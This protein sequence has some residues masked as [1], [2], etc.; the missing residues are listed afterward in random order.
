MMKY[1]FFDIECAN[2]FGGSGKICEFGYVITDERFQIEEKN[3]YLINP[4]ASFDW[5]VVKNMLAYPTDAYYASDTYPVVFPKIKRLFDL[6][7]TMMIGHTVDADAGYL[8]DEARRYNLPFFNYSFYDAKEMYTAY[9][10]TSKSVG[11]EE[12]GKNLGSKGP[13][14]A[15]KSVDDAEATMNTVKAM[16]SALEIPLCE[17][18]SLCPDSVGKSENGSVW[19]PVR[20]RAA[21]KRK[22]T[23][24]TM[25]RENRIE[26]AAAKKYIRFRNAVKI[27][28]QS[29]SSFSGKKIC[30]SR[31]YEDGHLKEMMFLIRKLAELGA[32]CIGKASECDLFVKYDAFDETGNTIRCMRL[33]A[34]ESEINAGRNVQILTLDEFLP[35]IDLTYEALQNVPVPSEEDFDIKGNDTDSRMSTIGEVLK[36][37]GVDLLSAFSVKVN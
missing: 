13:E 25:I 14:H 26:H 1:I 33:P 31:N 34:V 35:M 21:I 29:K 19:T 30:F 10:N 17:L 12:I 4:A 24:E 27:N 15:H 8:N 9:A 23:F 16:C 7:D 20:E 37:S 6:P 28:R 22:E 5:Y 11:L 36:A 32:E 18:I 3:H 2:C